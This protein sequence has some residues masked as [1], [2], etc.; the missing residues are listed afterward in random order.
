MKDLHLIPNLRK[1]VYKKHGG[2]F[3]WFISLLGKETVVNGRLS[4]EK[5]VK[6]TGT[7]LEEALD[8]LNQ[9]TL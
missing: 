5:D 8:T 9:N 3:M 4:R 1:I 6:I 7:T 2:K